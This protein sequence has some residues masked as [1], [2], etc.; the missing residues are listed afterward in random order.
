MKL[1]DE[2]AVV[3]RLPMKWLD[4]GADVVI[5]VDVTFGEGRAVTI[6]NTMDII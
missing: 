1:V 3:D 2:F 4:R 6:N 5:A